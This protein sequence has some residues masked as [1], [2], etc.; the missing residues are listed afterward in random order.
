MTG[1]RF[2]QLSERQAECLRL[3]GRGLSAKNIAGQLD[4]SYETVNAHL[5]A[6][7]RV[8]GVGRSL[9]AARLLLD[10]EGRESVGNH[11]MGMAAQGHDPATPACQT[12]T[13]EAGGA[14]PHELRDARSPFLADPALRSPHPGRR[15]LDDLSY[16]RRTL[17]IAIAMVACAIVVAGLAAIA[18]SL[19]KILWSMN[20]GH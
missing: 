1:R 3:L 8:L 11:G 5:K 10:S 16:A 19:Q 20:I 13:V 6:A 18:A 15:R 14:S 7:R 2:D 17:T 9:D 4:L 12:P